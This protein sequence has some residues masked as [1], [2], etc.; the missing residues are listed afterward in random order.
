MEDQP[1]LDLA[2][3]SAVLR[4]DNE[5]FGPLV[6]R[7]QRMVAGIAWRY[8]FR[9]ED[10]EDIV[11]EV[12][13]K[14]F[15]NLHLYRPEHPFST[16]LYRLAVNHVVDRTRRARKEQARTEMP[17]QVVDVAARPGQD[18]ERHE[19]AALLRDA[20]ERINPRYRETIWLIYIEG[21]KIEEASRTLDVPP[22]TI[23]TRLMRGRE[24]LKKVLTR[25]HPG[26]FEDGDDL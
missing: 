20:L 16:W 18:A 23:K 25:R 9:P 11:S 21:L 14:T 15:R 2:A 26:Y 6:T 7:Y 24:A 4:G 19:R 22:G 5:A 8:G 10:V 13:T 17:E 12:F 3:V 1:A